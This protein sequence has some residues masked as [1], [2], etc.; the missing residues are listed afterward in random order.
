MTESCHRQNTASNFPLLSGPPR[1]TFPEVIYWLLAVSLPWC[2]CLSEASRTEMLPGD[3]W[4]SFTLT[5]VPW[6]A[7]VSALAVIMVLAEFSALEMRFGR[8]LRICCLIHGIWEKIESWSSSGCGLKCEAQG[9]RAFDC[10]G[11][12]LWENF[13]QATYAIKASEKIGMERISKGH[14]VHPFLWRQV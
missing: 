9:C 14:L 5:M 13:E 1:P 4:E 12:C 3:Q 11:W 10:N 7:V 6:V 2:G 8:G